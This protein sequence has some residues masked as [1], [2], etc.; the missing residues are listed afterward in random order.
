MHTAVLEKL[1]HH[2]GVAVNTDMRQRN[3]MN[4][5]IIFRLFYQLYN[6]V[7]SFTKG[8]QRKLFRRILEVQDKLK[9]WK[10]LCNSRVG[11]LSALKMAIIKENRP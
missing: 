11:G 2:Y 1:P 4:R 7:S 6:L 3:G 5:S 10:E 8:F 9:I